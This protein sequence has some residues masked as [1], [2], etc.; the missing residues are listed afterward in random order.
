MHQV[1]VP[2]ES[3]KVTPAIVTQKSGAEN[4][5]QSPVHSSR[6]SGYFSRRSRCS[7]TVSALRQAILI[8]TSP[9]RFELG[10]GTPRSAS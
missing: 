4:V 6:T 8:A 5:D 3:G 10:S 2:S 1:S 7:R 9:G